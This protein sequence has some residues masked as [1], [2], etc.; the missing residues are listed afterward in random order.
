MGD[1]VP[2]LGAALSTRAHPVVVVL[3]DL[4]L[5][6]NQECLD[7]VAVLVD[8]L[9]ARSQVAIASRDELPLPVGRLRAEG[10]IAEIGPDDLAMGNQEAGSLLRAADVEL[11]EADVAELTRRTEGW[12]VALYLAAL[13][14]KARGKGIRVTV[15]GRD[16]FLVD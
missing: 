4:H 12:P 14:M 3:D 6:H 11:A 2:R 13:A 5:L 10:R 8:H 7:A 9:P 1:I 16:R 15:E